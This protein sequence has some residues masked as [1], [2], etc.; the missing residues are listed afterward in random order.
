MSLSS[1]MAMTEMITTYLERGGPV[2][3]GS[4]I[5]IVIRP[6]SVVLYTI[7]SLYHFAYIPALETQLS[8]KSLISFLLTVMR[9][10][11]SLELYMGKPFTR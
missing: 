7:P 6:V 4:N 8:R 2:V 9:T 3:E 5:Y 11:H 10:K 1:H